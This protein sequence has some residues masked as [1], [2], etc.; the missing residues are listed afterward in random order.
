MVT[1]RIIV[2]KRSLAK[3]MPEHLILLP[4]LCATFL[5]ALGSSASTTASSQPL[6][7]TTAA[8]SCRKLSFIPKK[9]DFDA[10]LNFTQKISSAF[11][12]ECAQ[13]CHLSN[14]TLAMFLPNQNSLAKGTCHFS[15]DSVDCAANDKRTS[16]FTEFSD[17]VPF[18]MHCIRCEG[19]VEKKGLEALPVI[20][21]APSE[22]SKTSL[23]TLKITT[24]SDT[25]NKVADNVTTDIVKTTHDSLKSSASVSHSSS[26]SLPSAA[27]S[28]LASH[29]L[30]QSTILQSSTTTGTKTSDRSST[31]TSVLAIAAN[32][33][34]LK[35]LLTNGDRFCIG[36]L[37]YE[38]KAP[39]PDRAYTHSA[40]L[41]STDVKEC[42][43][44]C[45]E[46]SYSVASYVKGVLPGEPDT[47][48]LSFEE[49][50]CE[51]VEQRLT[52]YTGRFPVELHC[53][54]CGKFHST[55]FFTSVLPELIWRT[56]V[57]I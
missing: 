50:Q 21:N 27:P 7:S 24:L 18:E 29:S 23:A 35:E 44:L 36:T 4:L 43:R 39:N 11:V 41:N 26:A 25:K 34:N 8:S 10:S 19:G 20:Q 42:V 3:R 5:L 53:I 46:K 37:S 38:A 40:T 30:S 57:L 28:V 12:E 6:S 22:L 52:N 48:L 1:Y 56:V 54:Q 47:C 9:P 45:Y 55:K 15:F 49:D 2:T 17:G 32:F 14:C 31:T 13:L 33:S 51:N 16:N